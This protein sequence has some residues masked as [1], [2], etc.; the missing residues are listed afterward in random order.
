MKLS[1]SCDGYCKVFFNQLKVFRW[2]K[3]KRKDALEIF[4][5]T[6]AG[7]LTAAFKNQA[8]DQLATK[9][10]IAGSF[11]KTDAHV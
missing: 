10:P 1:W 4:W 7:T 5:E 11:G 3:E 6:M 9:I 8:H 2:E